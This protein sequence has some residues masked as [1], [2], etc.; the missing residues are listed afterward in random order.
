[1]SEIILRAENL[2][3]SFAE[4]GGS[5][6]AVDGV[7]FELNKGEALGIAGGSGSGKSTLVRMLMH[8]TESD[9]GSIFL[10]ERDI[11]HLRKGKEL[12]ELFCRVQMVFQMPKESFDPRL[13]VGDGIC[14]GVINLGMSRKE[15]LSRAEEVLCRCGLGADFLKRYPHQ[16]SGGQNQRAAIARALMMKPEIMILDE[17]TSALDVTSQKQ[18][19]ELL[20]KLKKDGG[21][22]FIMISHD[23]ALIKDFCDRVM[24]MHDGR[25]IECGAINDVIYTPKEE[26]TKELIASVL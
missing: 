1:M 23:L 14:E 17:A 4:N 12:K 6:A 11:T 2:K 10:D 22:S 16:L 18:I 25:C 20:L 24:I 7:S 21:I 15:A 26:Y 13:T 9:S 19:L 5:F 8:I 3:K